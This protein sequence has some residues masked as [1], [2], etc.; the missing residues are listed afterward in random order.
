MDKLWFEPCLPNGWTEFKVHYRHRE[1]IYHIT[2]RC[3]TASQE[4]TCVTM[5]GRELTEKYLPLADDHVEHQVTVRI[6]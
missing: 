3:G 6:G 1:T 5:D 4:V 2:L